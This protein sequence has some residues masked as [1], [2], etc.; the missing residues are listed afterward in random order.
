MTNPVNYTQLLNLAKE[1]VVHAYAPYSDFNVGASILYESGRTYQGCNVEN[2]SYGLTLCAE[3]NALSNAVA[4]GEKS[5]PV[6]IAI[7]AEK[8]KRCYPCGAC[9]QWINE[10]NRNCEIVLE[11]ENTEPFVRMLSEFLPYTFEL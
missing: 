1:A 6:M 9:L 8:R 11:D 2:A 10:F 5:K 3:R 7:V 4:A